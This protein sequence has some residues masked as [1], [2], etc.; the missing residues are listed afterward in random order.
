MKKRN[1]IVRLAL[2]AGVLLLMSGCASS[3]MTR[4]EPLTL[5]Q[6]NRAMVTF[7]RP[8]LFGGAIQFGIWDGADFVG[9]LSAK[10]YVQYLV[11]PGEHLFLARAEN[12]S[13]VKA[14]LEAGKQYYIVGK[15]F[16]GIWKA[17]VALDPVVKG[18]GTTQADIDKWLAELTPTKVIPEKFDGYVAPRLEQ[19]KEAAAEVDNGDVKFEVLSREDGR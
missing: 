1:L 10:S 15:V 19:V 18:D 13:Y 9:V 12:W 17:R 5:E 6:P 8:S 3:V 11:E 14:D 16:P 7:V 4:T 2:L